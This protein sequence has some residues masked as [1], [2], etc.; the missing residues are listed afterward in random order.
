MNRDLE[1]IATAL[2]EIFRNH[3]I[4]RAIVFGSRARGEPSRKSDLDLT[5][6]QETDKRFLDRY[7]GIYLE[8][9]RAVKFQGVDLLIYTP[10]ELSRIADRRFIQKALQEGVIIYESERESPRG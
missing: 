1:D 3:G 10:E 5:L 9:A 4:L 8:I 7:D 2:R 6:I